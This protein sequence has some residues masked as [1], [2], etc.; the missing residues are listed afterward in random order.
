MTSGLPT[1]HSTIPQLNRCLSHRFACWRRS[2]MTTSLLNGRGFGRHRGTKAPTNPTK[3]L[4]LFVL[5]LVN[6]LC[7]PVCLF[8][9]TPTLTELHVCSCASLKIGNR[10]LSFVRT[11]SQCQF[12]PFGQYPY[13]NDA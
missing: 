11:P 8:P 3:N 7:S 12:T 4:V 5:R 13:R 9:A 6:R 2:K 10:N 1:L